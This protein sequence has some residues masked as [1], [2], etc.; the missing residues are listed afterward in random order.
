MNHEQ[1]LS[2]NVIEFSDLVHEFQQLNQVYENQFTLY[3]DVNGWELFDMR[4]AK[5]IIRHEFRHF[6]QFITDLISLRNMICNAGMASLRLQ[7]GK[8]P[9]AHETRAIK[10]LCRIYDISDTY[11]FNHH[12]KNYI[13]YGTIKKE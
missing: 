13:S 6:R 4:I 5:T 7:R 9:K 2:R 11:L 3:L 1:L 12:I 10:R 8:L